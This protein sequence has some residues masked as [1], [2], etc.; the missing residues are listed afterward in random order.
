MSRP[1]LA[2]ALLFAA[3]E[4]Q[5]EETA[6]FLRLQ[7][8]ARPMAMGEAFTAVAD[9]L[10]A[11]TVNPAGLVLKNERGAAFSHATLFDGASL[12]FAA[13]SQPLGGADAALGVSL[14]RL[15]YGKLDGR[16]ASRAQT[17]SF[18]AADTAVSLAYARRAAPGT[19]FGVA[20]KFLDSKI[21]NTSARGVA[22]D[23]GATWVPREGGA[24]TLGAALLNLG[25]GVRRDRAREDLP[26]TA[27]LG[28]AVRPAKPLLLSADLRYRPHATASSASFG[29]EY[30]LVEAFRVRAGYQ[31]RL[32]GPGTVGG[33]SGLG[34][35][36]GLTVSRLTVDYSFS[37]YGELGNAQR[38]S[39]A[40]RF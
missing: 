36:F 37:P 15:S 3:L 40:L 11:M 7:P 28:A 8:G 17:G 1:G 35:G 20:G 34:A 18:T 6:A 27:A 16:D 22:A 24:T 2:V 14:Q 23:L 30:A 29:G 4:S 21:A 38:V 5:A 32:A 26:T 19:T 9:D 10:N 39:L 25:P 13:Y 33:A 31:L 12:D